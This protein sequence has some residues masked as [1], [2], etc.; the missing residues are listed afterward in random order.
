MSMKFNSQY[1][2]ELN[3]LFKEEF[4]EKIELMKSFG[5]IN[6]TRQ[7]N[8]FLNDN[9]NAYAITFYELKY[10]QANNILEDFYYNTTDIIK[11]EDLMAMITVN[12]DIKISCEKNLKNFLNTDYEDKIKYYADG[13]LDMNYKT[14]I[15]VKPVLNYYLSKSPLEQTAINKDATISE[16]NLKNLNKFNGI[17]RKL[18]DNFIKDNKKNLSIINEIK[19]PSNNDNSNNNKVKRRIKVAI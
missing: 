15:E 8:D 5:E 3:R 18:Q 11:E 17:T 1:D 16:E 19:N 14:L 10:N 2:D 13:I 9:L 12:E 4:D 6:N 7:T